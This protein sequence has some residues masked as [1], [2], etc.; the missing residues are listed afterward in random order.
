MALTQNNRRPSQWLCSLRLWSVAACCLVCG[1][2][3]SWGHECLFL[4]GVVCCQV[5]D[6]VM[7]QSMVC[8]RL[9]LGLWGSILLGTRMSVSCGCCVLS[10]RGLCDG[11]IN[12]LWP[13][14]A[15]FVGLNPDGDTNVYFLWVLCVVR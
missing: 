9:L 5:E 3:S 4:V 12:G 15:W 14:A 10:G 8:G 11:P 2:E 1:F 6:S 7:G 13:L